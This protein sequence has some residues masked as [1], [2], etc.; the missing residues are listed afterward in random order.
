MDAIADK[1]KDMKQLVALAKQIHDRNFEL[2]RLCD[3]HKDR[4]DMVVAENKKLNQNMVQDRVS[5]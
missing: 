3:E 5:T 2:Q 1:E 4:Y